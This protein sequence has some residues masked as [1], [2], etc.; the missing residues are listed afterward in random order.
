[1]EQERP[2]AP[3][4]E[5]FAGLEDPRRYNR[6]HKLLDIVVISICAVICGADSWEDIELFGKSKEGWLRELLELPHGIPAHDTYRRVFAVLDAEQFQSCFM[7]W[8]QAV[9][10]LTAGQVIAA[11]G[12]TLRRSHD[13]SEGKKALQLVSAWASANGV[14]L[15][16]RKVDSESNEITAV[17]ELL[18]RLEVA[19][20]IVTLDAIHCQTETV[21]TIVDKQADYVL[22]VKE[23]QP[24]LL[25]TLQ[26]LF[27][28]PAEMRWVACDHSKTVDKGHG[29]IEIRECWSTSDPEYLR[30]IATLAEWQGLESI[31]MVQTERREGDE[32]TVKR[33][34]FISSLKSDAK[35]LLHA[36]RTHWEIENKVHW[37]LD[38][39]FHEDDCRIRKGNG[40]EN[41]AVL[42]HIALNL[43]RR[44]KT[45]KRSLKAKRKKAA[46]DNDYLFKV[47]AG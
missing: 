1:M 24:W 8:I 21:K 17:P 25:E 34:Y 5:H 33:R 36:V 35:R 4:V 45:V 15:G 19:G 13:R 22:P 31:A 26:G 12:K 27:D 16:Q 40:A 38:V 3:I 29:R 37:V 2:L 43:L 11:D 41:F 10:T 20:C 6:R 39:A 42:R 47:L 32:I 18:D 46:W 14:V 30:Y 7:E 44:E 23:N 9:D 28:D